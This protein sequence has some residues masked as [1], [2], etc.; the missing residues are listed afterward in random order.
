M[1]VVLTL[2]TTTVIAP[3]QHGLSHRHE[4]GPQTEQEGETSLRQLR[5]GREE[6]DVD[7]SDEQDGKVLPGS[8]RCLR[9]VPLRAPGREYCQGGLR[10]LHQG[11]CFERRSVSC[12]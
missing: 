1:G 10:Q 5:A 6:G 3:L 7:S 2:H 12:L 9:D 4:E 8:E 11:I